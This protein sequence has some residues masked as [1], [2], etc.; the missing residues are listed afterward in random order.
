MTSSSVN[1][2]NCK[3]SSTLTSSNGINRATLSSINE[4]TTLVN[5]ITTFVKPTPSSQSIANNTSCV[6]N[7]SSW[8]IIGVG[9]LLFTN[10]IT[11]IVFIISCLWILKR[12]HK[13]S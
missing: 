2:I 7:S 10:L 6:E 13:K 5:G 4:I 8:P 11:V 9:F 12:K 1:E 3:L